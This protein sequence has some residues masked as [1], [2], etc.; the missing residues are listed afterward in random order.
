[1]INFRNALLLISLI[2]CGQNHVDLISSIDE[3]IVIINVG[4]SERKKISL[5]LKQINKYDPKVVG[6]DLFFFGR[7]NSFS[8]SVL[9]HSISEI[10][11]VVLAAYLDDLNAIQWPDSIFLFP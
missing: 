9:A 10:E 7:T 2:G 4:K 11:N 8:D 6:I 1:M 3:N 5:G